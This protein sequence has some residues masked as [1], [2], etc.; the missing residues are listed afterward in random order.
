[1]AIRGD[2]NVGDEVI[3]SME[4]ALWVAVRLL[5][6][7]KLPDDDGLV[8]NEGLGQQ[9]DTDGRQVPLEAVKIMSGFSDDVAI[10]VT[11]PLWPARVPR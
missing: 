11:Q 4:D 5:L 8:Y 10:A 1:M 3:V 9:H 7:G 2:D 6:A